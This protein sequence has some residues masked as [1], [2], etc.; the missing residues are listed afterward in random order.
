MHD[1]QIACMHVLKGVAKV[2]VR[3]GPNEGKRERERKK[4]W[5]ALTKAMVGM[6]MAHARDV[7]GYAKEKRTMPQQ[8]IVVLQRASE[9]MIWCIGR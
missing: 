9:R 8:R 1:H 7:K 5:S 4:G 3:I 6:R 2:D